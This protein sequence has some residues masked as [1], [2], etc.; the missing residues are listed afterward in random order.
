MLVLLTW[1][2]VFHLVDES[3]V[4]EITSAE[5]DLANITRVSQEHASRTLRSAD[6]VIR[7]VE[8]RYL[9]VGNRLDL[10]DLTAKGVIDAEIFNQVGIIDPQGI[11]ILSN[12]QT[13]GRLDLSDRE[14]FRV[15]IAADTGQLFISKPVFG[16][17]NGNLSIQP[18]FLSRPQPN[19]QERRLHAGCSVV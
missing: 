1:W 3:R 16:R 12:R 7:F 2:Q 8:S 6:Q 13:R 10:K 17:T 18:I 4:R 15:H 5:R 14:H 9:E 11:L 19:C